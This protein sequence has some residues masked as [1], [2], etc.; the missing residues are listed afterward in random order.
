MPVLF[1]HP[2]SPPPFPPVLAEAA[3]KTR[4]QPAAGEARDKA[5]SSS[6]RAGSSGA[7]GSTSGKKPARSQQPAVQTA[8]SKRQRQQETM[9]V[10]QQRSVDGHA[11]AN[12]T[13]G[14]G[15]KGHI[16]NGTRHVNGTRPQRGG[17][18]AGGGLRKEGGG[19]VG[20]RGGRGGSVIG[21]WDCVIAPPHAADVLLAACDHHMH[22][23][24][25]VIAAACGKPVELTRCLC[26]AGVVGA[27][28]SGEQMVGSAGMAN[29]TGRLEL[30]LVNPRSSATYTPSHPSCVDPP[31]LT[32]P[33]LSS[34]PFPT[35]HP[36]TA[37]DMD[38][39][40]SLSLAHLS[41][42]S[43]PTAASIHAGPASS[44]S[45]A[46]LLAFPASAWTNTTRPFHRATNATAAA[47]PAA[48]RFS[49]GARGV[50]ANASSLS[51]AA[52]GSVAAAV[53]SILAAPAS[54]HALI[55]TSA[56]PQGAVRGQMANM[57]RGGE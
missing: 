48:A 50:W 47:P 32:L 13:R 55:A 15:G 11:A 26:V 6:K 35:P 22:L 14:T 33:L 28:M 57:T 4:S 36:R 17:G 8:G 10:K 39:H 24:C 41:S 20:G 38:V 21:E 34:P 52:G 3:S 29:A 2:P 56:F 51:A 30:R 43:P 23:L 27:R 19:A 37:T 16:V 5:A 1:L 40:Y 7:S 9:G 18:A 49:Y 42:P 25:S 46:L 45:A 12:G 53:S 44:A 54:F 31:V